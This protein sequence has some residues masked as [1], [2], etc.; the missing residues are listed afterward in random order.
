MQSLDER[1]LPSGYPF[2]P[3]WEITPREFVRRR[4]EG[5]PLV[6]I[7]CRTHQER[8]LARIEGSIHVPLLELGQRL[9]E[10]RAHE[11]AP[12]VVHCHHG[13]RSLQVTAALRDAGFDDV[14]SLAGGIHL[15]SL[16]VDSQVPVY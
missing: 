12:V 13:V 7:D 6:L 4:R 2:Q 11:S 5:E 10:L 8:E 14:R 15:W 1:G 9:G 3:E 16:D